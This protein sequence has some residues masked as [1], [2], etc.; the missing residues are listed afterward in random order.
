M[1]ELTKIACARIQLKTAIRL[2]S[3]RNY[4]ASITLSGAANEVFGQI[5][6]GKTGVNSFKAVKSMYDILSQFF[7][8][9]HVSLKSVIYD[10]NSGYN[11]MKHNNSK[12]DYPVLLNF[13]Y[14]A[15]ELIMGAL[16][17]YELIIWG[18]AP[19]K[20]TAKFSDRF[21]FARPDTM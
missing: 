3:S 11:E 1:E 4:V 13:E 5:A 6:D 21:E 10:L 17:N 8:M 19:D 14:E 16:M 15:H 2:Y 12:K 7:K 9:N 18:T 20:L